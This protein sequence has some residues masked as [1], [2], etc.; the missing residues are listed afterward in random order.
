MYHRHTCFIPTIPYPG[1]PAVSFRNLPG[2]ERAEFR[3][4]LPTRSLLLS[5]GFTAPVTRHLPCPVRLGPAAFHAVRLKPGY[6]HPSMRLVKAELSFDLTIHRTC[7]PVTSYLHGGTGKLY[8]SL[9]R[10][11]S[12]RALL[13]A[14]AGTAHRVCSS[15]ERVTSQLPSRTRC[16]DNRINL[17]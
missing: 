17:I 10:I 6:H 2:N 11:P 9:L 3:A 12:V 16:R 15:P 1:I 5:S 13:R 8:W 4:K 7:E 14:R